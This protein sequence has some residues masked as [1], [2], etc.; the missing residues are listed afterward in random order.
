MDATTLRDT[1][2]SKD[3]SITELYDEVKDFPPVVNQ[4]ENADAHGGGEVGPPVR[5]VAPDLCQNSHTPGSTSIGEHFT[6]LR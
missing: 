1:K 5:N 3:R 4:T 2:Q 6:L